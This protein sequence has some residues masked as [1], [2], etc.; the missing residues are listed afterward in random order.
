MCGVFII[1]ICITRLFYVIEGNLI[2]CGQ[3]LF[4]PAVVFN[5]S[6]STTIQTYDE[7]NSNF[8][9]KCGIIPSKLVSNVK[10]HSKF[11][12]KLDF[13]TPNS[14][15]LRFRIE[16]IENFTNLNYFYTIRKYLNYENTITTRINKFQ[17]NKTTSF[18]INSDENELIYNYRHPLRRTITQNDDLN[19]FFEQYTYIICIIIIN[20]KDG[21]SFNLPFMCM[22]IYTDKFYNDYLL[23]RL[24]SRLN[25]ILL[26]KHSL[27]TI[28][29]L[30]PLVIILLITITICNYC[31]IKNDLKKKNARLKW[32]ANTIRSTM[33]F[34]R[35]ILKS[36]TN[37]DSD[38]SPLTNETKNES[39]ENIDEIIDNTQSNNDNSFILKRQ[40]DHTSKNISSLI[41]ASSSPAVAAAQS[42][43]PFI[44]LDKAKTHNINKFS[45]YELNDEFN[46]VI[47]TADRQ[48]YLDLLLKSSENNKQ[49]INRN[50]QLS[51]R[52]FNIMQDSEKFETFNRYGE[53]FV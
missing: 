14:F 18:D 28:I 16:N 49:I 47:P 27:G 24:K 39:T 19:D 46:Q 35:D 26:R 50:A 25:V 1:I 41:A 4:N 8:N 52:D 37:L 34:N 9:L 13:L 11:F 51:K 33:I 10:M 40:S 36:F 17:M 20:L 45:R 53:S 43:T 6:V 21:Y 48:L 22:D 23:F 42:T 7:I 3:F 2:N 30:A 31:N 38:K 32:M 12:L 44:P 15:K 5:T 29:V